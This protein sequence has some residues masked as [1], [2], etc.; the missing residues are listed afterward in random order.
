MAAEFLETDCE[1]IQPN[2]VNKLTQNEN[3]IFGPM[4]TLKNRLAFVLY[5]A[6]MLPATKRTGQ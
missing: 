6:N 3:T 2:T 4:G 1:S 5:Y